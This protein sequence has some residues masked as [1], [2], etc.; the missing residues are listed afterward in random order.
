MGT[1]RLGGGG[2]ETPSG[3]ETI[4]GKRP[5]GKRLGGE[6]TRG[7]NGLG[8]KRPGFVSAGSRQL[9]KSTI[10][11]KALLFTKKH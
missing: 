7:G 11:R 10:Y 1:K 2:G 3:G 4:R 9:P 6:S 5:G 8:A